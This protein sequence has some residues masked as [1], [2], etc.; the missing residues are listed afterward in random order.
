MADAGFAAL[1]ALLRSYDL[2]EL[3]PWA[4]EQFVEGRTADE[5]SLG[6][7]QQEAFRRKY[8]V[9]FDREA[10]GKAPVSVAEVVEFR[11]RARQIE[12][13]YG[14][15]DG[16]VDP[17]RLML[18]DVSIAE[19]GDRV[20]L[21]SSYVDSRPDVTD[22]LQRLYGLGRG[23]A[24]AFALDPESAE[25]A[26]VRTFNAAQVAAQAQR[27]GFGALAREEAEMLTGLGVDEA[28]AAQGFGTLT[29]AGELTRTLEGEQPT[30]TRQDELALVAGSAEAAGKLDR[31]ARERRATFDEGGG[32]LAG[33]DGIVGLGI[34]NR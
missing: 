17:D 28:A 2:A 5:V 14:M 16:F 12:R 1:E 34:A 25:P 21:A 15:P 33:N 30:I 9:I 23:A 22:Q 3:L 31:R 27:Q 29:R 11:T 19:L 8:R 6:L 7:R 10:Q 24:I 4:R 26:I 32:F 18:A 13:M 20:Q